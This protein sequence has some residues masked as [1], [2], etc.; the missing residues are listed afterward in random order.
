MLQFLESIILG[1]VEGITEWLPISS[2]GHMLLLYDLF[3][4]DPSTPFWE[5]YLVVIQF[6]AILAVIVT[7]FK[8]LWPFHRVD[9]RKT[10]I[11][12]VISKPKLIMWLKIVV[13]CIPAAIV[14]VF[15]DDWL[16]ERLYKTPVIAFMLILVGVLFILVENRNRG[17]RAR[18]RKISQISWTEAFLIGLFQLVAAVFPGTSR[19]GATILGGVF[20]GLSK[21]RRGVHLLPRRPRDVRCLAAEAREV[22]RLLRLGDHGAAGRH[23]GGLPGLHGGDPLPDEVYPDP[24]FQ[25]LRLVP[26]R[27]RRDRLCLVFRPPAGSVSLTIPAASS[28]AVSAAEI[29]S[30]S[31]CL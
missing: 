9:E 28:S 15:F 7:Y 17:H 24:R 19:S 20:L 1:I 10:G 5:M 11:Y 4:I 6:G 13:S 16:E 12:R 22:R 18:V 8:R 23:D 25:D 30:V 26:H 3:G 2:T 14:G 31:V 21:M 29:E 27:P